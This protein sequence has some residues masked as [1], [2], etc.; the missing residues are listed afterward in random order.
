M[1]M[2]SKVEQRCV[3]TVFSAKVT[4]PI[5]KAISTVKLRLC[6]RLQL[7]HNILGKWVFGGVNVGQKLLFENRPR[8][9]HHRNRKDKQN[10]NAAEIIEGWSP[11]L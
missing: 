11:T 10:D 1:C 6:K 4:P 3:R 5:T 9:D 2:L 7:L 8:N